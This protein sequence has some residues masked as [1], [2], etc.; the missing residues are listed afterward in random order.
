M[1]GD[2]VVGCVASLVHCRRRISK[3]MAAKLFFYTRG[4]F[5]N[6]FLHYSPSICCYKR[7]NRRLSRSSPQCCQRQ[8]IL[9]GMT[10]LESMNLQYTIDIVVRENPS[11]CNP[12]KME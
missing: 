10:L 3:C 2:T 11:T 6:D 12:S 8:L 7:V 1:C 4:K 5:S 9:E